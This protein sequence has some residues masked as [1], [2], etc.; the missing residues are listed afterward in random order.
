MPK[1]NPQQKSAAGGK[2]P[3]ATLKRGQPQAVKQPAK[4]QRNLA[5]NAWTHMGKPPQIR[6]DGRHVIVTHSCQIG[7]VSRDLTGSPVIASYN[8]NARNQLVFPWGAN[9]ANNYDQAH[10]EYMKARV[11]PTCGSL[12]TGEL[13]VAFDPDSADVAPASIADMTRMHN[14]TCGAGVEECSLDIR[15]TN[16]TKWVF[17]GTNTAATT[18][19]N[20]FGR[21]Y[22]GNAGVNSSQLDEA[23]TDIGV[24][25][26][27]YSIRF[28][29]PEMTTVDVASAQ[30]AYQE[31]TTVHVVFNPNKSALRASGFSSSLADT[32]PVGMVFDESSASPHVGT[33][34]DLAIEYM[35]PGLYRT[36]IHVDPPA[37][38]RFTAPAPTVACAEASWETSYWTNGLAAAEDSFV[39]VARTVSC[40]LDS[41]GHSLR[42]TITIYL[43]TYEA[44]TRLKLWY[45]GAVMSS[46]AGTAAVVKVITNRQSHPA[47]LPLTDGVAR[48]DYVANVAKDRSARLQAQLEKAGLRPTPKPSGDPAEGFVKVPTL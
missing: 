12:A 1:K 8:L 26:I 41:V 39:E 35:A 21:L 13:C 28:R 29:Y 34:E 44:L 48:Q 10:L 36:E 6:R 7:T 33:A 11:I 30:L 2:Q 9:I 27:S 15:N 31:A 46:A 42:Y 3:K 32:L 20:T 5:S 45:V 37:G 47:L 19:S 18:P 4:P 14:R 23:A 16:I 43:Q 24:I 22:I 38:S 40:I 17:V 25:E